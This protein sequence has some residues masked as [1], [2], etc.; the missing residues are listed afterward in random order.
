MIP[1]TTFST[2][3]AAE[4]AINCHYKTALVYAIRPYNHGH[5]YGIGF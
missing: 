3:L 5:F 1:P 4:T 2:K